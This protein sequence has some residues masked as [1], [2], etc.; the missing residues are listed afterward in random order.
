VAIG[1][2]YR[3]AYRCWPQGAGQFPPDLQE[4]IARIARTQAERDKFAAEQ[5]KLSEEALKLHRE[6]WLLIVG[7]VGEFAGLLAAMVTAAKT[8]G[9]IS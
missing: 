5:R 6:R 7:A 2:G 1:A 4:Q 3:L 9:W 8:L